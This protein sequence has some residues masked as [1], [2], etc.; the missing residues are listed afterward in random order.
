MTL[1][2]HSASGT[3]TDQISR[4]HLGSTFYLLE[5]TQENEKVPSY[6][7]ESEGHH[8]GFSFDAFF[9]TLSSYAMQYGFTD[10]LVQPFK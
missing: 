3:T 5:I 1:N 6:A 7:L 8:E 2:C 4:L 9:G 10:C